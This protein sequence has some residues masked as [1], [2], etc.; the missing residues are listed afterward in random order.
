LRPVR[1]LDWN[2]LALP[3]DPTVMLLWRVVD[4]NKV[5]HIHHPWIN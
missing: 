5:G 2:K 3:A 4:L 1:M